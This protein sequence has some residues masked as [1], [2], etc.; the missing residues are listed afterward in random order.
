MKKTNN[1]LLVSIVIIS[2]FGLLMIY[3][4]SYVW[5]DYKFGDSFKFLKTQG[6]F[7]AVGYILMIIISKIDYNSKKRTCQ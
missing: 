3:S 1:I 5:A 6:I 7:L 4:A 2:L